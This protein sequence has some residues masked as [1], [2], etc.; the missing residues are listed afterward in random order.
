MVD[1][2]LYNTRPY[3]NRFGPFVLLTFC[4]QNDIIYMYFT[5]GIKSCGE[6]CRLHPAGLFIM[7]NGRWAFFL[8]FLYI[9]D[10][11]LHA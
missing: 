10:S 8:R 7:H 1:K 2:I 5:D 9:C 6:T 4:R 3:A 11:G